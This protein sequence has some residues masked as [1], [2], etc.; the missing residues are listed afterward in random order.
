[1]TTTP[2]AESQE[3][4]AESQA[5]RTKNKEQRTKAKGG[6]SVLGLHFSL[7]QILVHIACW[8]PFIVLIWDFQHNQLTANPIQEATFRTGKTALILLVLSLVCTPLNTLFGLKQ[9][10]PLRRPLGLYAFFYVCIHL[11]IFVAVDFGLDWGLIKE[12]IVEKRYVLVGFSAFLLL[13]PLALTSTKGWQRR[14]G[15]RWKSLHRLVYLAAPLV[16]IHFLWLVK[17]DIGEPLLFGAI[18]A[19]LL[20]LRTPRVRQALVQLRYRITGRGR[21][22][23]DE[24]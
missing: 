13:L 16:V 15:K 5:P 11:L 6:F 1:M 17:A 3:P 23:R 18:V 14:L 4:R 7:L 24:A 10:L 22:I 12:A 8:L 19:A 2:Q 21:T 20:L 9:V